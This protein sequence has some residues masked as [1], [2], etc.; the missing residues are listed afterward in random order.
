[1]DVKHEMKR[2]FVQGAL[3][4]HSQ[5]LTLTDS[6]SQAD[7]VTRPTLCPLLLKD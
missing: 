3:F 7:V 6:E 4:L 1:M 5:S 2:T